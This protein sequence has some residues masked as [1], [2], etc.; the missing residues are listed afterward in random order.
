MYL[1]EDD[2]GNDDEIMRLLETTPNHSG[3]TSVASGSCG[4][5]SVASGGSPSGSCGQTSVA[6]GSCGHTH[7]ANGSCGQTIVASGSCG[8]TS[9]ASGSCSR[10]SVASGSVSLDAAAIDTVAME[11]VAMDMDEGYVTQ[12]DAPVSIATTTSEEIA[13]PTVTVGSDVVSMVTIAS[14]CHAYQGRR[15]SLS[16]P[17]LAF[18]SAPPLP[19]SLPL[20][21]ITPSHSL[22]PSLSTPIPTPATP[23]S[24]NP[25]QLAPPPGN[26]TPP[27]SNMQ[28]NID[29]LRDAVRVQGQRLEQALKTLL[30]SSGQTLVGQTTEPVLIPTTPCTTLPL[31]T[32]PVT[33]SY[34]SLK[35]TGL[36]NGTGTAT[37]ASSWPEINTAHLEWNTDNT[38]KE[39][40]TGC[41]PSIRNTGLQAMATPSNAAPS[42]TS[43]LPPVTMCSVATQ[44]GSGVQRETHLVAV[45]TRQATPP[46]NCSTRIVSELSAVGREMTDGNHDNTSPVAA[47]RSVSEERNVVTC[48]GEEEEGEKSEVSSP[49]S[50]DP[51]VSD[52]EEGSTRD[53]QNSEGGAPLVARGDSEECNKQIDETQNVTLN[54]EIMATSENADVSSPITSASMVTV[55]MATTSTC[56]GNAPNHTPPVSSFHSTFSVHIPNSSWRVQPFR[57]IMGMRALPITILPPPTLTPSPTSQSG[58][59]PDP[60]RHDNSPQPLAQR[61]KRVSPF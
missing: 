57:S 60:G 16:P 31:T 52:L 45:E 21:P 27:P 5:T 15:H 37:T 38:L 28:V 51:V 25:P 34:A 30:P 41:Y 2:E 49:L 47:E 44:A 33:T 35:N 4:R 36:R 12:N 32:N 14:G 9:V 53:E 29:R 3:R 22:T 58:A 40:S 48:E 10:T 7:V 11:I 43:E 6:S 55:T 24:V 20:S 54:D 56:N 46:P 39:T 26:Q 23:S 1:L 13:T 18:H 59:G 19:P 42:L 50:P 8:Q 17:Q 61:K